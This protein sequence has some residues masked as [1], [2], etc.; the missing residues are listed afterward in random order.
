MVWCQATI[1]YIQITKWFYKKKWL[2]KTWLFITFPLFTNS[3][4]FIGYCWNACLLISQICTRMGCLFQPDSRLIC[5]CSRRN[6]YGGGNYCFCFINRWFLWSTYENRCTLGAVR[7]LKFRGLDRVVSMLAFWP[8]GCA[9]ELH[10]NH[11][12]WHVKA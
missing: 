4:S 5:Y 6:Y 7:I 2:F 11:F 8:E 3:H 10:P 1:M 9:L 12:T